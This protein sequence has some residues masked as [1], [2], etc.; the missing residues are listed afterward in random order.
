MKQTRRDIVIYLAGPYRA[1]TWGKVMTNV[2]QAM[3][4]AAELLRAGFT[5]ICPHSMTH[6][7]E[8]YKLEDDV[9]LDSD[10]RL[11]ERCDAVIMLPNWRASSGSRAEYQHAKFRDILAWEWVADAGHTTLFNR[12]DE[13]FLPRDRH[14]R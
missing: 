12:I 2:A 11:L 13:A 1:D 5:V 3:D 7:F 6:S 10:L 8:M 9:F 4:V 14:L